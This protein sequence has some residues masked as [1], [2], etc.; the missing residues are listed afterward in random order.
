MEKEAKTSTSAFDL[1]DTHAT[2]TF[3]E[4]LGISYTPPKS[5]IECMKSGVNLV[6][7]AINRIFG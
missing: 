7:S 2:K 5:G 3:W 4:F 6:R 1:E